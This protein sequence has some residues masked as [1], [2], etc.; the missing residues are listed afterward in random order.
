MVPRRCTLLCKVVDSCVG[1]GCVL[2]VGPVSGNGK[3]T[4]VYIMMKLLCAS[5]ASVVA[6]AL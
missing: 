6:T 1:L 3:C 5:K 4:T 2:L